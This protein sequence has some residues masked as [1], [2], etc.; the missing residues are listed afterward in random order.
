M[1]VAVGAITDVGRVRSNNEDAFLVDG[2]LFAVADGMG[3]GNAGEVASALALETLGRVSGE[4]SVDLAEWV[5]RANRAVFDRSM[6]DRSTSGMGTTLTAV[7]AEGESLRLAHVGDSRAYL[8]RDGRLERLTEDHTRV[9]R[10]VRD[11]M[12][13]EEQAAQHPQRNIITRGL[14]LADDVKVDQAQVE[15]RMGDRLLLCTDGLTAM[16]KE[17]TLR[18]ILAGEP[19]PQE[20]ARRLVEAANQAG[21]ADNVTAV[22]LDVDATTS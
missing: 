3:G 19:D 22:V 15:V 14:G 8:L 18:E 13:T 20:A 11:G 21:G 9:A 10:M 2:P 6:S 1:K 12:I 4:G 16:V 17:D 7:L 5:Q